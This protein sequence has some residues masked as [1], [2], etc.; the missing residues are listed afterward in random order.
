MKTKI[1]FLALILM[2]CCAFTWEGELNPN[3]F[4]KWTLLGVQPSPD[5]L[6]LT[7]IKNPDPNS[8]IEI[9][10]MGLIG[11][12]FL[13]GY[14]YFKYGQPYSY[15]FDSDEEKYV[16]HHFTPEEKKGCMECHPEQAKKHL[17]PI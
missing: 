3:D 14:R 13:I 1:F 15:V 16:R 6:M 5:G 4:D 9:V 2:L 7:Y 12:S 11:D 10:A 8:P 17:E